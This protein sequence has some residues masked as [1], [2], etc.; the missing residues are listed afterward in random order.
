MRANKRLVAWQGSEP[1][2]MKCASK[3]EQLFPTP[4]WKDTE[5]FK[6]Y[7]ATVAGFLAYTAFVAYRLYGA[8]QGSGTESTVILYLISTSFS[9]LQ[10]IGVTLGLTAI[11]TLLVFAVL[12]PLQ[13]LMLAAPFF[14]L[15]AEFLF[16]TCVCLWNGSLDLAAVPGLLVL[17]PYLWYRR[18]K[19]HIP[20][21]SFMVKNALKMLTVYPALP[22]VIAMSVAAVT[23]Y[24]FASAAVGLAYYVALKGLKRSLLSVIDFFVA[25][26]GIWLFFWHFQVIRNIFHGTVGGTYATYFFLWDTKFNLPHPTW[27]SFKRIITYSFG[28]ILVG[29]MYSS[30]I[31]LIG[32]FIMAVI[33]LENVANRKTV[34][35]VRTPNTSGSSQVMMFGGDLLSDYQNNIFR[36][37]YLYISIYGVSFEKGLLRCRKLLS[38]GLVGRIQQAL[39]VTTS[40]N[41]LAIAIAFGVSGGMLLTPYF[42]EWARLCFIGWSLSSIFFMLFVVSLFCPYMVF[43]AITNGVDTLL[44]CFAEDAASVKRT[45]F[46]AYSEIIRLFGEDFM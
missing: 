36:D 17:L 15:I 41:F 39:I 34:R 14:I 18:F 20:F 19:D 25:L 8:C 23:L 44:M 37:V 26:A 11:A 12:T 13:E 32:V 9:R 10:F 46:D 7:Y 16:S 6:L 4:V 24:I 28:S 27:M 35:S 3:R 22:V 2:L 29:S 38:K 45:Q 42:R 33:L 1:R 31:D 43:K 5:I 40:M 21:S 30:M